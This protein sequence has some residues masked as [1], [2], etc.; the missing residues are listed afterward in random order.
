MTE[1]E[2]TC[3]LAPWKEKQSTSY[4]VV[5]SQRIK[6][7]LDNAYKRIFDTQVLI[8]NKTTYRA[9]DIN[10]NAENVIVRVH[11]TRG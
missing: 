11:I 7:M 10:M 1:Y 8:S 9:Y 6:K 5:G 2:R 4:L 3:S